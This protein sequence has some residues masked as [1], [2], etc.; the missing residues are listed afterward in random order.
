MPAPAAPIVRLAPAPSSA[1][2]P[3]WPKT[4]TPRV[5]TR[6]ASCAF[7]RIRRADRFSDG[8]TSDLR[9]RQTL[10]LEVFPFLVGVRPLAGFVAL[11]EEHLSDPFIRVDPRGQ[12]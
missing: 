5:H 6:Q 7:R 3:P 9:Q 10:L 12:R 8:S 4:H 1:P 11:E 2:T